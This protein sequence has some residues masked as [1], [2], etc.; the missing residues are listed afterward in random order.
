MCGGIGDFNGFGGIGFDGGCCDPL[1]FIQGQLLQQD[2]AIRALLANA[3]RT[4]AKAVFFG[5]KVSPAVKVDCCG[6][7]ELILLDTEEAP[8]Q[9]GA[10]NSD[11]LLADLNECYGF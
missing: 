8:L 1:G 11:L 5:D 2:N 3:L 6:D 4:N 7:V 9:E 10:Q